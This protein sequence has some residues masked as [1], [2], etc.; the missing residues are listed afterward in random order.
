MGKHR[1]LDNDEQH[2][3]PADLPPWKARDIE[4]PRWAARNPHERNEMFYWVIQQLEKREVLDATTPKGRAALGKL[5]GKKALRKL[6]APSNT[7]RKD[8]H[9]VANWACRRGYGAKHSPNLARGIRAKKPSPRRW[10][11]GRGNCRISLRCE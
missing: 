10:P 7:H 4:R 1:I 3:C 6:L 8:D 2:D 11:F 9:D 5:I